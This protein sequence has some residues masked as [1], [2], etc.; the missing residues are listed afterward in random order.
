MSTRFLEP[1]TLG[2]LAMLVNGQVHGDPSYSLTGV[3]TLMGATKQDLSFLSQSNYRPAMETTQAGAVILSPED[4]SS[5]TTNALITDN[6]HAAY[7]KIAMLC[8]A[9][10]SEAEGEI[11]LTAVID[12]TA[13]VHPSAVIGEFVVVGPHARI[14]AGTHVQAS[15]VV[16]ASVLIG[17]HCLI[18]PHV[19]LYP[20]VVLGNRVIIHANSVI[21]SD[22][23]GFAFDKI[24]WLKVPQLG[25]VRIADDV[26]IGSHTTIDRGAIEDTIIE[27]GVKIDNHVQVGHN[28]VIGAYTVVAGT[29]A[30]AGSAKIGRYC[31][32]GG[33]ATFAGHITV[34]DKVQVAGMTTVTRSITSP[35]TYASGTGMMPATEWRKSVVHFRNL[36]AIVKRLRKLEGG[37]SHD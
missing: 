35:G 5:C 21:G 26:E 30:F 23:F 29:A 18:Y 24:S 25:A 20:E 22:G 34:C 13:E 31:L 17:D 2:Q 27:Q 28:V 32:I 12:P 19:T 33:G 14:G 10:R 9:K 16:G 15:V 3:A 11:S 6:P 36:D 4:L 7:A 1:K 8:V 37:T